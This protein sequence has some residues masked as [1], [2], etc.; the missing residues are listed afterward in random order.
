MPPKRKRS[1]STNVS[2]ADAEVANPST[3]TGHDGDGGDARPAKRITKKSYADIPDNWPVKRLQNELQAKGI[4]TSGFKKPVLLLLY[5]QNCGDTALTGRCA[6]QP[7]PTA[8]TAINTVEATHADQVTPEHTPPP[9]GIADLQA[10]ARSLVPATIGVVHNNDNAAA[11]GLSTPV[12]GTAPMGFTSV[13]PMVTEAT[14][15][16]NVPDKVDLLAGAVSSLQQTVTMLAN[17][18]QNNMSGARSASNVSTSGQTVDLTQCNDGFTL[19][20]VPEGNRLSL[21]QQQPIPSTSGLCQMTSAASDTCTYGIRSDSIPTVETMSPTLKKQIQE[22]KDVN[23]ALLL[24]PDQ[25]TSSA[26]V[27]EAGGI[28]FHMKAPADPRLSRM[29]TIQQFIVAFERYKHTMIE[30]WPAR[31]AELDAYQRF[32]VEMHAQFGSAFYRYH[33]LFS[34]KAGAVLAQYGQVVNW[35]KKDNDIYGTVTA[36]LRLNCCSLCSDTSHVYAEFCPLVVSQS[37]PSA[38]NYPKSSY[39]NNSIQQQHNNSLDIKGRNRVPHQGSDI[40]N[41][42]N[43]RKGCQNHNCRFWHVCLSCRKPHPKHQCMANSI[44]TVSD[45]RKGNSNSD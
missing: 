45:A 31:R 14:P 4:M 17:L 24:M 36:G 44:N 22:G 20:S 42:F 34:A 15:T 13:V 12:A 5:K 39:N 33:K 8:A 35:S 3:S 18:V 21:P 26:R 37:L 43:S 25:V 27:I 29:L 10:A 40:C 38:R 6:E 16:I 11:I 7:T 19:F 23:L 9:L 2:P 1:S 32:I 41:N 30:K 28:E